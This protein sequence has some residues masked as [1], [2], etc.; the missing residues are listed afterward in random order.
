[1]SRVALVLLSLAALSV[2]VSAQLP[3]ATL[4]FEGLP[5]SAVSNN[6]TFLSLPFTVNL[7]TDMGACLTGG[8]ATVTLAAAVTGGNKTIEAEVTPASIDFNLGVTVGA[9]AVSA[10]SLS[11]DAVVVAFTP[12]LVQSLTNATLTVTGTTAFTCLAAAPAGATDASATVAVAF[13]PDLADRIAAGS[14]TE[15]VPGFEMVVLVA[16]LGVALLVRRN[17]A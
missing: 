5:S 8:S 9:T 4:A 1:M 3:A 17:K 11:A 14:Q 10:R 16:A 6:Q 15:I 12:E 13:K 2:S 7:D